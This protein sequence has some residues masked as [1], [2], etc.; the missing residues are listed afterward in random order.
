MLRVRCPYG[1]CS[2]EKVVLTKRSS[3]LAYDLHTSVCPFR[4]FVDSS[5]VEWFRCRY[6]EQGCPWSLWFKR[7]QR[8]PASKS[9]D[10]HQLNCAF[11]P[12]PSTLPPRPG[13]RP[14]LRP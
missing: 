14:P 1:Q 6:S 2:W 13:R 10:E 7:G 8:I 9:R 12:L 4:K 3:Q 5:S 11:R